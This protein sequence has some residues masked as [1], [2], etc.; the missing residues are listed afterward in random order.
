MPPISLKIDLH[1]HA[2][3]SDGLGTP[4]DILEHAM[5]KGLDGLAITDHNTL[6]GYFRAR[7]I[8]SGLF[9]VPGFEVTTEAGH[10]LVLGL[11][12]LPPR[13]RP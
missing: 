4:E 3:Y 9:I 6:D 8:D 12:E 13:S 7:E 5:K 11:D 1:V 10:I 2:H